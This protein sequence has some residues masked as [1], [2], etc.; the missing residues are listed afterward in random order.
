MQTDRNQYRRSS[1]TSPYETTD[2]E[3]EDEDETVSEYTRVRLRIRGFAEE[4]R[5]L[6]VQWHYYPDGRTDAPWPM[7]PGLQHP[8]PPL[9]LQEALQELRGENPSDLFE[10]IMRYSVIDQNTLQ[11]V[12]RDSLSASDVLP[13]GYK[14]QFLSRIRC[15][16][17]PGKLYNPGPD[18]TVGNFQ[19]HL[20]TRG[21]R[22]NVHNRPP[23][24]YEPPTVQIDSTP[25][26][27]SYIHSTVCKTN[28]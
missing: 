16:D 3:E 5:Q 9:W 7:P 11:T 26:V 23:Y 14:A 24:R 15:I 13:P 4:R 2:I 20:N 28:F 8:P 19:M 1:T 10:A 21:H 12:R 27:P 17:C 25:F 6:P 22:V 18:H